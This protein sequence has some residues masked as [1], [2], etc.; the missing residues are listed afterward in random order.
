[1][2]LVQPEVVNVCVPTALKGFASR[3]IDV[4]MG[5]SHTSVLLESGESEIPAHE[6]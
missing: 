5:A 3:V 6:T 4:S 2:I 1:V